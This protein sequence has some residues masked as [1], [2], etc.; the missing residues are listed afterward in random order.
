MLRK[1]TRHARVWALALA[2]L[3]VGLAVSA[4]EVAPP[5]LD[6]VGKTFVPANIPQIPIAPGQWTAGRPGLAQ[7]NSP[8]AG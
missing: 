2:C 4:A 3:G 1:K 6:L 5:K 7:P 8:H